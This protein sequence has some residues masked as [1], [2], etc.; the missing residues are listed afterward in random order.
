MVKL[1]VELYYGC[2]GS[3]QEVSRG[4]EAS[5]GALQKSLNI[6]EFIIELHHGISKGSGACVKASLYGLLHLY[7]LVSK[8]N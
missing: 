6:V 5:D 7:E 4:G 2:L 8:K 3:D 1:E